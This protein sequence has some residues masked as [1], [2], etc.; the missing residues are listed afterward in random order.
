MHRRGRGASPHLDA[1]GLD[2]LGE[3]GADDIGVKSARST[4][5][6]WGS[7]SWLPVLPRRLSVGLTWGLTCSQSKTSA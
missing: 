3:L 7:P 6:T 5:L 1:V 2:G 4:Q